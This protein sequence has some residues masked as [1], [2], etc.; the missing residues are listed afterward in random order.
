MPPEDLAEFE[1]VAGD[2]LSELGY[3]LSSGSTASR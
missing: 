3:D 2:L 1:R